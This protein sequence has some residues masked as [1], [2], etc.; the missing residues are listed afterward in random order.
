[1]NLFVIY[2]K[3]SGKPA[4]KFGI[5]IVETYTA[6][7]ECIGNIGYCLGEDFWGRGLMT[8]AVTQANRY[9]PVATEPTYRAAHFLSP[10]PH[11]RTALAMAFVT[12]VRY[13][14]AAQVTR[15]VRLGMLAAGDFCGEVGAGGDY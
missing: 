10:E 7:R 5:R 2:D 15:S 4:G 1:M 11:F 12:C 14:C 9:A 13:G 6:G 3:A 8:E